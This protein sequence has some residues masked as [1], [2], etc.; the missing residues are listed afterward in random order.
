[1]EIG[2]DKLFLF[3][4]KIKELLRVWKNKGVDNTFPVSVE[5]GQVP[6]N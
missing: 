1:M 5:L 2:L 3:P 6:Q 4:D